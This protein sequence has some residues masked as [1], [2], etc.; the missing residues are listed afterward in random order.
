MKILLEEL[1]QKARKTNH[2][3]RIDTIKEAYLIK[4]NTNY[5][6]KYGAII[7]YDDIRTTVDI[8]HIISVKELI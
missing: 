1:I 2:T 7:I 5:R 3:L 6:F 8:E 4:P